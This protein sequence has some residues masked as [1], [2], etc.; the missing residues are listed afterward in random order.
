MKRVRALQRALGIK[1]HRVRAKGQVA[2]VVSERDAVRILLEWRRRRGVTLFR[3][4]DRE[5]RGVSRQ[6]QARERR[7][8]GREL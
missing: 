7:K 3:R 2:F 5:L 4:A 6:K 8:T 1:M